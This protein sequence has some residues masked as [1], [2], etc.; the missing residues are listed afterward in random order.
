MKNA[1]N[2]I[3][4]LLKNAVEFGVFPSYAAGICSYSQV[5]G[6]EC[7]L[8]SGSKKFLSIKKGEV[9][10]TYYDLASLTKPF[11]TALSIIAL[12][13]EGLISLNGKITEYLPQGLPEDKRE[14]TI[15]QLLNHS[16]GLP[17][18]RP[19]FMH[20]VNLPVAARKAELRRLICSEKLLAKPGTAAIYSDFGYLLLGLIIEGVTGV[21]LEQYFK[22]QIVEPLG[23]AKGIFFN[24]P[25]RPRKARE[26]YVPT[27]DCPWRG[28]VL[29]G[30]VSDENCWVLGG[31]A[32]HAGLFGNLEAVLGLT[33]AILEIWQGR[34]V[35]PNL[36]RADLTFFL[37]AQSQVAGS[38]WALGFDRPTPGSSSSGRYLSP[39]SVGHLGFTGTSFWIDPDKGLVV[40]LL[41]NRVHPS[42]DNIL[43]R[44][45]RPLFHDRVVELLGLV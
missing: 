15:A 13:G 38:T 27:E 11:A 36:R 24:P 23:L 7:L 1:E 18:H 43:I 32:G 5:Y 16:S 31:V 25:G 35:H 17:A 40:V 14:I 9:K 33:C 28:K 45:F 10:K 30:E 37:E 41:T 34:R 42:R 29:Q 12:V 3:A 39:R 6:K 44:E 21:G 22:E 2:D 4:V 19:Y 20:L 8:I 26:T